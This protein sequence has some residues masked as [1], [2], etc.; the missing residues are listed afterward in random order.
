[1]GSFKLIIYHL[2][3]QFAMC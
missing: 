3:D 1:V 2:N